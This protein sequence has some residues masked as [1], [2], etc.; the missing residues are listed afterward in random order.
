MKPE[1]KRLAA[2]NEQSQRPSRPE[3]EQAV[4]TLLRSLMAFTPVAVMK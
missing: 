4:R 1:P 2:A 3:A